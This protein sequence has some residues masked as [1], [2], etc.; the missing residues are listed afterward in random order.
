M[1]IQYFNQLP[2]TIPGD[3]R[4]IPNQSPSRQTPFFNQIGSGGVG[5]ATS[6]VFEDQ[7]R[8]R[9]AP[10]SPRD[11]VLAGSQGTQNSRRTV[12]DTMDVGTDPRRS[13]RFTTT[14]RGGRQS[15]ADPRAA[16]AQRRGQSPMGIP[17][18][19]VNNRRDP[20][21]NAVGN[22]ENIPPIVDRRPSDTDGTRALTPELRQSILLS[23]LNPGGNY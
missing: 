8:R 14:G 6:P 21:K 9:S 17:A 4:I 18:P 7:T 1:A 12:F 16:F 22:V 2:T 3:P 10:A 5:G 11:Q 19:T 15:A 23:M 13:Q 20:G